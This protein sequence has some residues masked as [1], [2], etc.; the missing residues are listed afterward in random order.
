MEISRINKLDE[1]RDRLNRCMWAMAEELDV[2]DFHDVE[3]TAYVLEL[4]DGY[5]STAKRLLKEIRNL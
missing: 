5:T 1:L 3:F 4:M 2:D